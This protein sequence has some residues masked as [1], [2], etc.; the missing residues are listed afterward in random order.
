M[1]RKGRPPLGPGKGRRGGRIAYRV[2]RE[3]LQAAEAEAARENKTLSEYAR[4]ALAR[5]ITRTAPRAVAL[6]LVESWTTDK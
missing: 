2:D 6:K 3:L 1:A 5:Q 4:A